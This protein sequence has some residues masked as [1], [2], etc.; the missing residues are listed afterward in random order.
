MFSVDELLAQKDLQDVA[1]NSAARVASGRNAGGNHQRDHGVASGQHRDPKQAH[2]EWASGLPI[3]RL[4]AH[5]L[6]VYLDL[7]CSPDSG[8]G[9]SRK[10][11][12][13]SIFS[14]QKVS[15]LT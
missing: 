6:L 7:F 2:T 13:E 12:P 3:R 14:P 4:E 5:W 15:T 9:G 10:A 1:E 8:I 11:D